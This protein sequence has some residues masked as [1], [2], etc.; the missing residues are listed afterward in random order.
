MTGL[1]LEVHSLEKSFNQRTIF[2]DVSFTVKS[3]EGFGI[4]GRNGSGKS[5]LAK[6]LSGVL[7]PTSGSVH[8]RFGSNSLEQI[9]VYDHVGFI[10]PYLQLYEEFTAWENLDL[11]RRIRGLKVPDGMLLALLERVDLHDRK[12]H[13]VRTYSSGMKQRLKYAFALLHQPP[14]LILD[15]PT[16]NLDAEGV[17]I[18]HEI[19]KE[20]VEKGILI[21]ATNEAEDLLY[22]TRTLD[23]D[24]FSDSRKRESV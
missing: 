19:M 11:G 10:A 22:C 24:V 8:Y 15:E 18:V 23:L 13:L 20:Q 3:C 21:V 2:F 14:L 12:N 17:Q 4:V 16:S 7:T 6:I 9:S 1:F 5:T